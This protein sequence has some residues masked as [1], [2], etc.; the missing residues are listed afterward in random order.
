MP[1]TADLD[2][3][4]EIARRLDRHLPAIAPAIQPLFAW[5]AFNLGSARVADGMVTWLH[6]RNGYDEMCARLADEQFDVIAI[7]ALMS[8]ARSVATAIDLCAAALYRIGGGTPRRHPEADVGTWDHRTEVAALTLA[9]SLSGWIAGIRGDHSW[10]VLQECRDLVTHRTMPQHVTI[11]LALPG[12][13]RPYGCDRG[14]EASIRRFS[15]QRVL[16]IRPRSVS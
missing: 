5:A 1:N 3:V 12:P 14:R 13:P 7:T 8:S 9:P 10:A 16:A 15:H 4:N 6:E 11:N 2:L